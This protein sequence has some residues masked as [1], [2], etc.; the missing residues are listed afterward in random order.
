M[1]CKPVS[2][3]GSRF[4][5]F[6]L[7]TAMKNLSYPLHSWINFVIMLTVEDSGFPSC[8]DGSPPSK[9]QSDYLCQ[10]PGFTR[11]FSYGITKTG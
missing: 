11:C 2:S 9:G 10:A 1:Q 8:M 6:L 4:F 3:Q 5:Y 7:L